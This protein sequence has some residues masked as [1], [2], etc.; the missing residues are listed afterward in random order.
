MSDLVEPL[1]Y[2]EARKLMKE[3]LHQHRLGYSR[4]ARQRMAERGCSMVDA[5]NVLRCGRVV[6]H[7]VEHGTH[8]Y[9]W[10]T[11]NMA[12]VAAFRSSTQATVVT[13]MRRDRR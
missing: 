10:E 2:E 4:H 13:V 8:R 12:V 1:D 5:V 9:R 7:I 6:E 11:P 3:I